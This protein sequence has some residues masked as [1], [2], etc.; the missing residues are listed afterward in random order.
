MW[1]RFLCSYFIFVHRGWSGVAKVSCILRHRGFQLIL[2]YSWARLAILVAGKGRGN[3]F[4]S[5]VS[6]LSFLFL[7]RPCLSLSSPL[8]SLL[9]LFS[10]SLGDY[11]KW[12][13][14]V[15]MLNPN[16]INQ[17]F[18][19]WHSFFIICSSS[20]FWC[21]RKAVLWDS[22]IWVSSPFWY[23]LTVY[24]LKISESV[25]DTIAECYSCAWC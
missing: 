4:I 12:P 7:F 6:F 15:D 17:W 23:H 2:A 22:R 9:S 8:L 18:H 13:T 3:V 16:T 5:S 10:L 20:P 19:M 1:R 14:R 24:A 11:T 21:L 25:I